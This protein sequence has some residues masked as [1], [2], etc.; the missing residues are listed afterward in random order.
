MQISFSFRRN[1]GSQSDHDSMQGRYLWHLGSL[2]FVILLSWLGL[3]CF[4]R[5]FLLKRVELPFRSCSDGPPC[6]VDYQPR[7]RR[8]IILIVDALKHEFLAYNGNLTPETTRAYQNKVPIIDRLIRNHPQNAALFKFIADPPTTTMQRIKGLTTGSLPTF[9]DVSLNFA[10]SSV[11]ED[12]IV[13]QTRR[14]GKNVSFIGDDTWINLYPNSFTK[15]IPFPSFDVKDLDV[16][17]AGVWQHLLPEI[18]AHQ[19]A[20]IIAHTLGVDHCGHRY[21]RDH[22]EMARKLSELN[23]H[24]K[25]IIREMD[26]HT[27]LFVMGDHGMTKTGDHGGDS[28]DEVEAGLFVY[29][30][31]SFMHAVADMGDTISQVDFVPTISLL[32]GHPIPFSNLGSV[33]P[34]FFPASPT[35]APKPHLSQS[36]ALKMNADQVVNFLRNYSHISPELSPAVITELEEALQ[37]ATANKSVTD[38]KRFFHLSLSYCR[39]V[40]ARFD[41]RNIWF[42]IMFVGVAAFGTVLI[43]LL[44]ARLL[45][46]KN[47]FGLFA[48]TVALFHMLSMFSNSFQ[49][50]E[51]FSVVTILQAL[52]L[53]HFVRSNPR[54]KSWLSWLRWISLVVLVRSVEFVRRCREEQADCSVKVLALNFDSL[55]KTSQIHTIRLCLVITLIIAT[56]I[57]CTR[58]LWHRGLVKNKR[59]S[60]AILLLAVM[61]F[62]LVASQFLEHDQYVRLILGP[63]MVYTMAAVLVMFLFLFP[64]FLPGLENASPGDDDHLEVDVSESDTFF[65]NA[66]LLLL[67]PFIC[68]FTVLL[69]ASWAFQ[70]VFLL[71]L[72]RDHFLSC[73]SSSKVGTLVAW[74]FLS[75]QTFFATGHQTAFP[76]LHWEAAFMGVKAGAG[77]PI[78]PAVLVTMETYAG[79]IL[80]ALAVPSLLTAEGTDAFWLANKMEY[81]LELWKAFLGYF[82]FHTTKLFFV[83]LNASI[84]RR[85][86]MVWKIFAPRFIFEGGSFVVTCLALTLAYLYAL[87]M[88]SLIQSHN[89]PLTSLQNNVKRLSKTESER[90]SRKRR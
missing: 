79:Q 31:Q 26:E 28:V 37:A 44:T 35:A 59:V 54:A 53:V 80:V 43:L 70:L 55:E 51:D 57:W 45:W 84:N 4:T 36:Q 33:I 85:H 48:I 38:W 32:L 65:Q 67:V 6:S 73:R 68:V 23:G 13:D 25:N 82:L 11:G 66:C 21:G 20:L 42:G 77:S 76:T 10:A 69:N 9:V 63:R 24:I 34:S 56:I 12:N 64:V 16:V 88:F 86:L 39:S 19:A 47:G 72:S 22:P 40:W 50:R 78:L 46:L 17:D 62:L 2:L 75:W 8:A 71:F 1:S 49:V 27:V 83:M 58:S 52:I 30:S 18:R 3:Y 89:V 81:Y 61:V 15:T 90:G 74:S 7:F 14:A 60:I 87:R 41:D 29:S 5:G